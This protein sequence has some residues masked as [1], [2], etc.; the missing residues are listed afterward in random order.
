[1]IDSGNH[2]ITSCKWDTR[3]DSKSYAS[4][5]QT[6]ISHWSKYH[7]LKEINTVFDSICPDG[8]TL[9]IK[10]LEI[11]LGVIYYD[12]LTNELPL[13]LRKNLNKKLHQ[14]V[15]SPNE[16]GKVLEI[17]QED[18]SYLHMVKEFLLHGLLPWNHHSNHGSINEIFDLQM[19]GNR[20]NAIKM[21]VEVG[22]Y[23]NARKRMAWQFKD[24][25]IKKIIE[26]LEPNN[27]KHIIDF[28]DEFIKVQEKQTLVQS[29]SQ[30]LKKNLWFWILNYLFTERG[31]MFNKINF[32]RSNIAQMANHFNMKYDE[33]FELIEEAID[34]VNENSHV[35]SEFIS[36]L[37]LL[38]KEQHKTVYT[39]SFSIK[40]KENLW[41]TLKLFLKDPS[42]RIVHSKKNTFN[43]LILSLSKVD[44]SRFKA[45][46]LD[47]EKTSKG[48]SHIIKDLI[49][50]SVE[51][52]FSAIAPNN[53]NAILKHLHFL[54]A[55]DLKREFNLSK[56][57]L[58]EMG[59]RHI[60]KL[61]G[62]T[63]NKKSFIN[64]F[65]DTIENKKSIS[66][67]EVLGTLV[68][69]EIP[70][71]KKT[72]ESIG[73]YK[74]LNTMHIAE[75]SNIV[76]NFSKET[77]MGLLNTLYDS[78]TNNTLNQNNT[79][80][81]QG[82]I[83]KWI[84]TN[85]TDVWN[86]FIT[87]PKKEY[88]A[89]R[90]LP[91]LDKHQSKRFLKKT[92]SK[93]ASQIE[94]IQ[95]TIK[96]ILNSTN[97]NSKTLINIDHS[98]MPSALQ[99]LMTH[100]VPDTL[101]L[102]TLLLKS[103]KRKNNIGNASNFE[104]SIKEI[105][106]H[107]KLKT[108]NWSQ[109]DYSKLQEQSLK[110]LKQ[111]KVD[112]C[113][114]LIE[115]HSNK[116]YAVAK[117]IAQIVHEKGTE[118]AS[119]KKHSSLIVK[120]L[121]FDGLTLQKT[122]FKES[123]QRISSINK[124]L[125]T[126]QLQLVLHDVF[127]Q[128]IVNYGSHSGNSIKF[129][130]LFE[131]ALTYQFPLLANEKQK[132][133]NQSL[134]KEEDYD[135]SDIATIE[136]ILDFIEKHKNKQ[137]T[138]AKKVSYVLSRKN[139]QTTSFKKHSGLIIEYLLAGG[140]SLQNR[141]FKEAKQKSITTR[142][143]ITTQQLQILLQNCFWECIVDY[144]SYKG[145]K[146][147]FKVFFEN[148]LSDR[149]PQN[150]KQVQKT[151]VEN[152]TKKFDNANYTYI[153][154]TRI[155]TLEVFKSLKEE[156]KNTNDTFV[157]GGR[158]F[159][160][161]E[162]L[163]LGLELSP[164]KMRALIQKSTNSKR[165]I[166]SLQNNIP[167]NQFVALIAK[168]TPNRHNEIVTAISALFNV[169]KTV[170]STK[171]IDA[172]QQYY[173]D[174]VIASIRPNTPDINQ[175]KELT[176]LTLQHLS[177]QQDVNSTYLMEKINENRIEIPRQLKTILAEAHTSFKL[178]FESNSTIDIS[179]DL[180]FCVSNGEMENLC[181]HLIRHNEIPSWFKHQRNYNS[182]T[183]LN[184]IMSNQPLHILNALRTNK[185]SETQLTQLFQSLELSR[186]IESLGKLYPSRHKH[187]TILKKLHDIIGSI[188]MQGISSIAI[189]DILFKK[190]LTAWTT[191]HWNLISTQT[192]W[193]ELSWEICAKR[194]ISK[195]AFF[196]AFDVVKTIM[197]A[198]FQ[199]TYSIIHPLQ[200]K[201][202]AN[203]EEKQ[204][205]KI[206]KETMENN[207]KEILRQGIAIP[208]AGLVLLNTYFIMLLERL[209]LLEDKAFKSIDAQLDAIH[210]LQYLVTGLTQ[211]EESFLTLN[212]VLCGMAP[213]TPIKDSIEVSDADKKL[214]DGLITSAIGYWSAIGKC[215]I[216][217]FRGNWLVREGL[218]TEEEDRWNLTVEKRPYDILM[219]KSPFSFS[220]I[221]LPWMTKPLH[222][223]WPF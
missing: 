156:Q 4:Q 180:K 19:L 95:Q 99:V 87:H 48:W 67:A 54:N 114:D 150:K 205:S 28:S 49:N 161:S 51:A 111:N 88:L 210:Y 47:V 172:L 178:I 9:K 183:L 127:W 38:S 82:T 109:Q 103:I 98:L 154:N 143:Q 14:I 113:I 219:L 52:L 66:R 123:S 1:M 121:L 93:Y 2:I 142:N 170:G 73:I 138:L 217:G 136:G 207:T 21:L 206:K 39:N 42:S 181:T 149:I 25:S 141:L 175:L 163:L 134:L 140:I 56:N 77:L 90:I 81:L 32:V 184:E 220:I 151:V 96:D 100:K 137:Q 194:G 135:V 7:M 122:M 31:T 74:T 43:E 144:N 45:L 94:I 11:D 104:E 195:M 115:S 50:P 139:T 222:V 3:F 46:V 15:T 196:K 84:H 185:T 209:G 130:A 34:K 133:N 78:S 72:I 13:K 193:N 89:I 18:T 55:L 68:N 79:I 65:V 221:R 167:F 12:D 63:F 75:S 16:H 192:I 188:S 35:N 165:I 53:T 105:L 187:L 24:Q 118:T 152:V 41:N 80:E 157:L 211:T 223:N 214:V 117:I 174:Y 132:I 198:P 116:Q 147:K 102:I 91:I 107:R 186:T 179:K 86:V 57:Q 155:N 61:E 169:A 120:Y 5:L 69:L 166:K 85:P 106:K 201:K 70:S 153:Q 126:Q 22:R 212:K 30:D 71:S 33:I 23:E 44:S 177:K 27:H 62:T 159:K 168:D 146:T 125:T 59:I 119:L 36:I 20:L 191:S 200:K 199:I 203:T 37:K 112:D 101:Q 40:K 158:S 8:Q 216:N 60:I 215:S 92:N 202:D 110:T 171:C 83:I 145:N 208:N 76:N 173:W 190:I 17:V 108:L 128:C 10:T 148:T 176:Q 64:H 164:K 189:Q 213:T 6:T 182:K 204:S 160:W 26:A 97:E 131:K 124:Q 218:L 162:L 29:S 129:K 58:W 197:P